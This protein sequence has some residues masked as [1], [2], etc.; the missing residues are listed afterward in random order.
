MSG[1]GGGEAGRKQRRERMRVTGIGYLACGSF[2][3]AQWVAHSVNSQPL[4]TPSQPTPT[5]PTSRRVKPDT[6]R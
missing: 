3:S 6:A 1:R 5:L 4:S 2:G